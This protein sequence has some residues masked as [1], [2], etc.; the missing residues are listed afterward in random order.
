MG[1]AART[2]EQPNRSHQ[3]ST[4]QTRSAPLTTREPHHSTTLKLQLKRELQ[5]YMPR[6]IVTNCR[7]ALAA[8]TKINRKPSRLEIV[9]SSRKQTLATQINRQQIAISTIANRAPSVTNHESQITNHSLSNRH[10]SRLENAV[11]H[12]KQSTALSSNRHF[13]R[14]SRISRAASC[15]QLSPQF[16]ER[17]ASVLSASRPVVASAACFCNNDLLPPRES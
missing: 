3:G 10:T 16:R 14:V 8:W 6:L 5:C 11:C 7:L 4:A 9:V 12:R 17:T 2:N 1:T 13:L 15:L